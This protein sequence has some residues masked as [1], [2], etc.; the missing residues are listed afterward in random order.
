MLA[1]AAL[2]AIIGFLV[3]L[4]LPEPAG[5]ALDNVSDDARVG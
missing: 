3:T 5:R 1:I 4:P 2:A